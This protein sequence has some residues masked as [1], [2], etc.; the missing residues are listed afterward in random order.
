M[1]AGPLLFNIFLNDPF[2]LQEIKIC[3]F[4]AETTLFVCNETL[5]SVQ[6]K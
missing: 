2:F 6:Q 1:I 5:E 3:N 4:T